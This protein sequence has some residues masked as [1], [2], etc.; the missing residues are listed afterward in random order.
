MQAVL[1]LLGGREIPTGVPTVDVP[2]GPNHRVILKWETLK[3]TILHFVNLFT[4]ICYAFRMWMITQSAQIYHEELPPWL[5]S[6]KNGRRDALIRKSGIAC[7]RRLLKGKR[8]YSYFC[9]MH[10]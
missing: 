7:E 8:C 2:S 6:V 1:L 3:G 10:L 5:G 9:I 4:V